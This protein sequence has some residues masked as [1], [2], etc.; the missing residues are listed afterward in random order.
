LSADI[1]TIYL[2][3]ESFELIIDSKQG[4]G[5]SFYI[6]KLHTNGDMNRSHVVKRMK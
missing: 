3:R 2:K 1:D 6:R 5:A 4:A